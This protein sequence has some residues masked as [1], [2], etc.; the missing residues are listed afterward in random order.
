MPMFPLLTALFLAAL[1]V[2]SLAGQT[3]AGLD[4][5]LREA[6]APAF[7]QAR[8]DSVPVVLL[9]AKAA[10]GIAKRRPAGQIVAVV[11]RLGREL[12]DARRVLRGAAP[13]APLAPAELTAA[14]DA[15]RLGARPED[16]GTLR[17]DAPVSAVLEIPFTVL[18]ALVERG[19]PAEA[20]R[21]VL[22]EMIAA[23]V[24]Q[25]RMIEI[26]ARVDIALRVGAQ[27]AA[28]LNSALQGLG[29]PVPPIPTP[30]AGRPPAG[31]ERGRSGNGT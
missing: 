12:A 19:V 16:V 15:L 28:A 14:A 23:G 21:Q 2:V 18:G 24:S 7:E 9:E 10:E 31:T 6:L 29:I 26:P 13:T 1:P 8:R 5:A 20:A 22:A 27:P 4:P 11:T 3:A 17:A 30:P 25:G